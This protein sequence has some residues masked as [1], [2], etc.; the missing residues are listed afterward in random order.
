M[1]YP[2]EEAI[3]EQVPKEHGAMLNGE[4]VNDPIKEDAHTDNVVEYHGTN[5][6]IHD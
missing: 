3:S 6:S 4:Q 1:S 5:T 2:P